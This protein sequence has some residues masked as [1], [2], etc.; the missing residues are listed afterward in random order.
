MGEL[1]FFRL[2][3]RWQR[4]DISD[5]YMTFCVVVEKTEPDQENKGHKLHQEKFYLDKGE[6]S[7]S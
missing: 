4:E 1:N 3:E 7:S 6:I 5:V 2:E